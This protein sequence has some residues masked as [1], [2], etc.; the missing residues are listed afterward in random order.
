LEYIERIALK[1]RV[2]DIY[3]T[4]NIHNQLALKS[5]EKLGFSYDG[6]IVTKIGNGFVMD[7]FKMG[8]NIEGARK[9]FIREL[10]KEL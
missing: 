1:K 9:M 4:V 10:D 3:L 2:K 5:Y 6:C 7:D 8:K